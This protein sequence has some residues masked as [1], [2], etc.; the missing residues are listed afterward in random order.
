MAL[1]DRF[2][3]GKFQLNNHTSGPISGPFPKNHHLHHNQQQPWVLTL[4]PK[5]ER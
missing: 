1:F 5:T 4:V 3:E 2:P